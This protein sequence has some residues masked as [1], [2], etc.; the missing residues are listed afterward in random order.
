MQDCRYDYQREDYNE[1]GLVHWTAIDSMHTIAMSTA[2]DETWVTV[3]RPDITYHDRES[4]WVGLITAGE[5][6][7]QLRD[8]QG[9]KIVRIGPQDYTRDILHGAIM[10]LPS[11]TE[12]RLENA[13]AFPLWGTFQFN[14]EPYEFMLAPRM[15]PHEED[16]APVNTLNIPYLLE[17]SP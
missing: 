6:N 15:N 16:N 10:K 14:D 8:W 11:K 7:K 4:H 1:E 2:H 17:E 3:R 9:Q 5:L 13:E 12:I